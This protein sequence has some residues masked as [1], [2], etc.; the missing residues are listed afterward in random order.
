M[1]N[2]IGAL[3]TLLALAGSWVLPQG[4]APIP[5]EVLMQGFRDGDAAAFDALYERHRNGV[6]RYMRRQVRSDGIAEELH[7]DVWMRVIGNRGGYVVSAKFTTWLYTIAHNRLMDHFR[8]TGRA[9]LVSIDE[10]DGAADNLLQLPAPAQDAPETM[11]SRKALASQLLAALDT[12]PPEQ[13]E[14]FV[15]QYEGELSVEEIAQATGVSRETAKSRLRYA[16]SK[17]RRELAGAT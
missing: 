17:L 5:D 11:L 2:P 14:A 6:Y 9:D 10:N 15:L 3:R 1:A 8:A 16:L 13:R 4:T 7:Q 12:L